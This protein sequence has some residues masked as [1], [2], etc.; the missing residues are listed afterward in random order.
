MC[1]RPTI[2]YQA[3]GPYYEK[4]EVPCRRCWSCT[5]NRVNDLIGRCL[6]EAADSE[7]VR[8]LTLTYDDKKV[9]DPIQTTTI[10]KKDFQNFMKRMR[11]SGHLC[12][13]I[14]AGEYGEKKGRT[15]FHVLLFGVGKLPDIPLNKKYQYL[16]EW[17]WGFTYAD[18]AATEKAVRYVAK[19]MV[20]EM[21]M[22]EDGK[23]KE[24]KDLPAWF[25]YSTKPLLGA[26]GFVNLAL[27]HAEAKLPPFSLHYT[28]PGAREGRRY[29][30][31]GKA[32][33]VFF[34]TLLAHWPEFD[35][36]EKTEWVQNSYERF[37][38]RVHSR[39][40]AALTNEEKLKAFQAVDLVRR[41]PPLPPGDRL[42]KAIAARLKRK[43]KEERN[44]SAP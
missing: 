3:V 37:K 34:S 1:V 17:P 42:D 22:K 25:T 38:K 21:K 20:K 40:F 14:A 39:K 5:E 41:F 18:D 2:V 44:G 12:R 16:A 27:Q 24:F 13:Y 29:V 9:M 31:S 6:F 28:P 11:R 4:K 7:W 43:Y 30:M 19:Y 36:H 35:T 15:H 26:Q 8:A 10:V 23:W 33:D 32:E